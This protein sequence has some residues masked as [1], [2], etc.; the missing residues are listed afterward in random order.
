MVSPSISFCFQL[1]I[2][3]FD[4]SLNLDLKSDDKNTFKEMTLFDEKPR[5]VYKTLFYLNMQTL[6]KL[7]SIF[8]LQLV[9][10]KLGYLFYG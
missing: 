10:K 8:F 5:W 9:E 2:T 4:L 1:I 7:V 6:N 3:L